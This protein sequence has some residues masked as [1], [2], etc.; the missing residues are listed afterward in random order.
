M[1]LA[2]DAV[3][4]ILCVMGGRVIPMF[5]QNG[6]PGTLPRRH[7]RLEQAALGAVLALMAAD[8]AGVAGLPLAA[9][10]A[11]AAVLHAWRWWLWQPWSTRRAPL[12]WI[13]QAGYAWVPV[14]LLLRALAA[15]GAVAPTL[16]THALTVGAVGGLVVGMVT[17]TARGHT[18][19]AAARRPVGRR[20]A[21]RWC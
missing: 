7:A 4:F 13:L 14:H 11:V 10:A 21:T 18:G 8:A 3:L 2:L 12:V 15:A 20:S 17:R 6:V 9:L 5:T 1:Q 19:Q 16:A